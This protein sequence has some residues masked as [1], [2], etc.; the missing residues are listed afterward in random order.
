MHFDKTIASW[1]EAIPLG[2]GAIGCLIWGKSDALRLSLDRCDLWDTA[3][4][5]KINDEYC[6]KNL[7][8]LARERNE[9]EI[10]R[11]FDEPYSRPRPT[12]LPAGKIIINCGKY[13]KCKISP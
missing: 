8:K 1:D 9:K 5:P 2:N 12:K 6:Y 7:V 4:S 11:I 10:E 13:E 3:D